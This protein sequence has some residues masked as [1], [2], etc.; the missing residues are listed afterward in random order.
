MK[1]KTKILTSFSVNTKNEQSSSKFN[2]KIQVTCS[3]ESILFVPWSVLSDRASA[4]RPIL[5]STYK[6]GLC[7][8]IRLGLDM[9]HKM[10]RPTG[11]K[12]H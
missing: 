8:I 3:K 6:N 5:G 4:N 9:K 7:H 12:H 11:Y 10:K 2:S 1:H